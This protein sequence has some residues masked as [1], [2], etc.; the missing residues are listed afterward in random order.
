MPDFSMIKSD[1][2]GFTMVELAISLTVIGLLLVAVLKGQEIIV[3]TRANSLIRQ[4]KNYDAG[5]AVFMD[6][7]GFLP[8]DLRNPADLLSGCNTQLCSRVGNGDGKV[9]N[10]STFFETYNFFTHLSR[11]GVIQEEIPGA[12][13]LSEAA[14]IPKM[15]N[16]QTIYKLLISAG[17]ETISGTGSV[18]V[19]GH[20]YTI[21]SALPS[22]VLYQI[23]QKVD[24]GK[25]NTGRMTVS[26]ANCPLTYVAPI[27]EYD[28][29]KVSTNCTTKMKA[30]F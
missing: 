8:G 5:V 27:W 30:E 9:Q 28:M 15:I 19:Q 22:K 6:S 10:V 14:S 24:D 29:T 18:A 16:A 12:T 21:S 25:P 3:N 7:Y 2:R 20:F 23:D 17:Y 1:Q 4:L 11:A 13:T 26:G